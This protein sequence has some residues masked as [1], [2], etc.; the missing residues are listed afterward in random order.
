[1]SLVWYSPSGRGSTRS[2]F[3]GR[4]AK[5]YVYTAEAV[6]ALMSLHFRLNFPGQ[7]PTPVGGFGWTVMIMAIAYAGVGLAELLRHS[8][9]VLADPLQRTG[10]FLPALPL[11]AFWLMPDSGGADSLALLLVALAIG[12]SALRGVGPDSTVVRLRGRRGVGDEFR[13][14]GVL[15][16]RRDRLHGASAVVVGAAGA[17]RFDQRIFSTRPSRP[18]VGGGIALWRAGDALFIVE[19]QT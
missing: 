4:G 14:V 10:I 13:A 6:L 7:L 19:R 18:R 3:P 15:W 17:D 2:A 11:I 16:R 9:D 12:R 1:M 8:L 5:S